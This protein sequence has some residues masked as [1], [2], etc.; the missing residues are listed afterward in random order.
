MNVPAGALIN[1]K[2]NT[3]VLHQHAPTERLYI[4]TWYTRRVATFLIVLRLLN[5]EPESALQISMEGAPHWAL[6]H[7]SQCFKS[8]YASGFPPHRLAF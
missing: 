5:N 6:M 1:H 7:T 2:V 3:L 8:T 4:P